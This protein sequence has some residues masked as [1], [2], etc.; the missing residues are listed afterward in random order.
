MKRI[1]SL[2]I[3]MLLIFGVIACVPKI[4]C[5][6]CPPPSPTEDPTLEPQQPEA[7]ETVPVTLLTAGSAVVTAIKDQDFPNLAAL[8]H[9]TRGL[10]LSPYPYI[11]ET[12]LL[13]QAQDVVGLL[14]DPTVYLWGCFDGSGEPINLSF[15]DY[16]LRFIYNADFAN[17]HMIGLNHTI[18]QGNSINNLTEFY[19][20]AE[21]VEY[22]FTGFDPQYEGMDW[23]S[24]IL[25]FVQENGIY[26]L[27]GIVHAQWTI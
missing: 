18:G 17:S 2:I 3:T 5:A 27:I 25:V 26:Y 23:Q 4:A 11:S 19:P 21:F 9:P 14:T 22:H 1:T 16:Y 13:F 24:L 20:D 10:R 8:V 6:P 12:D 15:A 7:S